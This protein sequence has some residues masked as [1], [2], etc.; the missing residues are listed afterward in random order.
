MVMFSTPGQLEYVHDNVT[1]R[2]ANGSRAGGEDGNFFL[3]HWQ[4]IL[5][6]VISLLGLVGNCTVVWLLG[7][8]IRRTP[9]SIYILN[10]AGADA[11][12]LCFTILEFIDEFHRY[13][14]G[15]STFRIMLS[16]ESTFYIAGLS[17]LAAISTERCLIVLFPLWCRGH[18]PKH[19]SAVVC[20]GIWVQAGLVRV[21]LN[22]RLCDE[23]V[24]NIRAAYF[25]LLTCIMCVSSLTFL[26]KIQ[27]CSQVRQPPRLYLL[28]L[29][30]VLVFLLFGLPPEILSFLAF[31][32]CIPFVPYWIHPFLACINSSVNPLIYFFLGRQRH[33]RRE[34]LRV[35]L[36]RALRE[37][38]EMEGGMRDTPRTDSHE[39]L[40]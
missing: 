28:V 23:V 31:R 14:S 16:L 5:I 18:R 2:G 34:P 9:F 35:V 24:L 15:G 21:I 39:M 1:E 3:Y 26:V 37:K 13:L 6:L 32:F 25:F 19:L 27:C 20:S 38:Q 4:E 11:L 40:L 12:F 29:L 30:T 36:Q 8:R 10:L 17:F 33:A 22:L 7:F